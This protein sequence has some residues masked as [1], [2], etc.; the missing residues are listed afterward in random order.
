MKKVLYFRSSTTPGSN[1]IVVRDPVDPTINAE[2]VPFLTLDSSMSRA[3]CGV[4]SLISGPVSRLTSIVLKNSKEFSIL[5]S[6]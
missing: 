2:I 4:I 3:A 1:S 6:N 5:T